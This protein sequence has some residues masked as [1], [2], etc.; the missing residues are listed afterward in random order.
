[1]LIK[2]I[3]HSV[4]LVHNYSRVERNIEGLIILKFNSYYITK[5]YKVNLI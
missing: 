4:Y 3:Q 5:N 1:M 2:L